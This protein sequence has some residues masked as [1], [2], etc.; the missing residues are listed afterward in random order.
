M[1]QSGYENILL[2]LSRVLFLRMAFEM[3]RAVL[4]RKLLNEI[5]E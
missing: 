1:F 2:K 5:K 3:A 4:L